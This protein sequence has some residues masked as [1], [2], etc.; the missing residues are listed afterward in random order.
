MIRLPV[1]F[2]T[3]IFNS[4]SDYREIALDYYL[5]SSLV[6]LPLFILI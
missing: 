6:A 1:I 5:V 3:E 4:Y 2:E